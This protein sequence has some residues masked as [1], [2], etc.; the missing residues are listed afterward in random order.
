MTRELTDYEKIIDML[1]LSDTKHTIEN[2]R[3]GEWLVIVNPQSK[4]PVTF[5]FLESSVPYLKLE[6]IEG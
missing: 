1:I 5:T 6:R 3:I 4:D 2:P